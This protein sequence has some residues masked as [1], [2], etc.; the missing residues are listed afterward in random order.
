MK[1][2]RQAS[3]L[4]HFL[5][6][7]ALFSIAV[8]AP[9]QTTYRSSLQAWR[10][11]Q[12]AELRAEK[13]WLAVAGLFWLKEGPNRLGA[14]PD[15]DILLPAGSAPDRV[16]VIELRRGTTTLT[17]AEGALVTSQG[18]PIRVLELK[19]DAAGAPTLI[20]V[21]SL[22]MTVIKRGERYG[23]RVW[24]RDSP[25]RREFAGMRWFPARESYRV[26]ARFVPHERPTEIVV[27]NVLGDVTKMPS[28]GVLIFELAGREHRLVPVA[29]EGGKL[30]IIFRDLTSGKATYGAGRFLYADAPAD[31]RVTLDFN[32]AV[33]PPCAFTPHATCP[34]PPKQNRLSVAVEAGELTYH[35][36]DG[37][38]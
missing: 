10:A 28:P 32:R 6:L 16:G 38:T 36:A 17:A 12:E 31:G 21:G 22:T 13:G 27:P 5:R 11:E 15:N 25:K 9:G 14:G 37:K 20:K 33:N 23:L 30:F 26:T 8:T 18:Q 24:D 4:K 7:V 19:A 1:P 29:A 35:A 34:L 3:F 2:N